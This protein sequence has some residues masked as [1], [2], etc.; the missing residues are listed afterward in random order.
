MAEAV[1]AST[2]I[3]LAVIG[4][5]R[6]MAPECDSG[7]IVRLRHGLLLVWV[8]ALLMLAAPA[9]ARPVIT[10]SLADIKDVDAAFIGTIVS[11]HEVIA[12]TTGPF[13]STVKIM[14]FGLLVDIPFVGVKTGQDAKL[15]HPVLLPNQGPVINGFG[16]VV[17]TKGKAYLFLLRRSAPNVFELRAVEDGSRHVELEPAILPSLVPLARKAKEP[18]DRATDVLLGVLERCSGGCAGAVWLVGGAIKRAGKAGPTAWRQRHR[19]ALLRVVSKSQH[20]NTLL[21]AY[22]ELGRLGVTSVIPR[23]VNVACQDPKKTKRIL[24]NVIN[25]LQGFSDAEQA[26]ALKTIVARAKDPSVVRYARSRLD[27]ATSRP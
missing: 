11:E 20:D 3:P 19:V 16:P 13:R 21:A 6:Y 10:N 26:R 2:A 17:L 15:R 22:T 24:S 25:W 4:Y 27:N 14:E 9:A 1:L 5:A 12:S 18:A 23:I 7:A 8:G